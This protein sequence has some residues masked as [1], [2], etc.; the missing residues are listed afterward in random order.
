MAYSLVAH[1]YAGNTVGNTATTSAINT[2]GATLLVVCSSD[3]QHA[4]NTDTITDSKGNT[5]VPIANSVNGNH[6]CCIWYCATPTVGTSHTFSGTGGYCSIFVSAWAGS[7]TSGVLGFH[8]EGNATGTTVQPGSL[9]PTNNGSLIITVLSDNN[10]TTATISS[11]LTILDQN[12]STSFE[13]KA[14]AYLI[15]STAAAINPT[16]TTGSDTLACAMA[17]FN[18]GGSTINV[19]LT[20]TMSSWTG[21][22]VKQDNKNLTGIMASWAGALVKQAR[23]VFSAS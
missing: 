3:Y 23:K 5:W 7:A 19:T 17:V 21:S 18:P 2:T 6:S 11:G 22:L 10:S 4:S 9:T 1:A 20:A 12:I 8:S 14:D 15:Q 13:G 16:W